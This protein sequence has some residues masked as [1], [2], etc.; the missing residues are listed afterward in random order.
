MNLVETSKSNGV[1]KGPTPDIG[2]LPCEIER[3][4]SG[5]QR[6]VYSVWKLTDEERGMLIS[7]GDIK[8]GIHMSAAIPPVS[9]EVTYEI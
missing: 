3:Y 1:Y 9:L 8:L 6:A 4:D 2:D 5:Q 7:G